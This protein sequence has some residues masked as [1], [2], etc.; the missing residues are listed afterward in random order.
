MVCGLGSVAHDTIPFRMPS[1]TAAS[2]WTMRGAVVCLVMTAVFVACLSGAAEGLHTTD[3]GEVLPLPGCTNDAVSNLM[4]DVGWG[5]RKP[6]GFDAEIVIET[7]GRESNEVVSYVCAYILK[8][9]GFSNVTLVRRLSKSG[10]VSPSPEIVNRLAT[11][12]SHVYLEGHMDSY[13]IDVNH[14]IE[15]FGPIGYIVLPGLYIPEYVDTRNSKT[16]TPNIEW[17]TDASKLKLFI[18]STAYPGG[19]TDSGWYYCGNE[20]N[21]SYTGCVAGKF[22]PPWCRA[23]NATLNPGARYPH[24]LASCIDI[25]AY[26]AKENRSASLEALVTSLGLNA[27]ISYMTTDELRVRTAAAYK[28]GLAFVLFAYFPD[29]FALDYDV[30]RVAF[31]D[32]S[33]QHCQTTYDHSTSVGCDFVPEIYLK[34]G[35]VTLRSFAPDVPK[36]LTS[37]ELKTSEIIE[38]LL[39]YAAGNTTAAA[40]CLWVGRNQNTVRLFIPTGPGNSTDSV[41]YVGSSTISGRIVAVIVGVVVTVVVFAGVVIVLLSRTLLR[42]RMAY[43]KQSQRHRNIIPLEEIVFGEMVGNGSFG[44]VFKGTWRGTQVAI[45]VFKMRG[46]AGIPDHTMSVSA[47]DISSASSRAHRPHLRSVPESAPIARVSVPHEQESTLSH[48][49]SE[50]GEPVDTSTLEGAVDVHGHRDKD[51]EE[52][53][54][55]IL[56]AAEE[57][58]SDRKSSESVVVSVTEVKEGN[59][60]AAAPARRASGSAVAVPVPGPVADRSSVFRASLQLHRRDSHK[61]SSTTMSKQHA[62]PSAPH[63]PTHAHATT[64]GNWMAVEA[65]FDNLRKATAPLARGTLASVTGLW[66]R[67]GRD[68]GSSSSIARSKSSTSVSPTSSSDSARARRVASIAWFKEAARKI[69]EEIDIMCTLRHP[70]VLLF[71]GSCA[72]PN[73]C[74]VTE[75]M[76][77]NLYQL[78][79]DS[80]VELKW[81]RKLAM[82]ADA[83]RGVAYLHASNI[84]HCDLK[85]SNLLVNEQ[86]IV[87]VSDFGLTQLRHPNDA[88]DPHNA[89]RLGTILWQAP[90]VL[91]GSR[92]TQ[93]ADCYSF[94]IILWEILTRSV[95]YASIGLD[96]RGPNAAQS[97]VT[98]V[99]EIVRFNVRPSI[100]DT[101][102]PEYAQLIKRCWTPE[103]LERPPFSEILD[104]LTK[105]EEELADAEAGVGALTGKIMRSGHLAMRDS[106][107]KYRVCWFV[108]DHQYLRCFKSQYHEVAIVAIRAT[109]ICA[110][111]REIKRTHNPPYRITIGSSNRSPLHLG[112]YTATERDSW[113]EALNALL[114]LLERRRSKTTMHSV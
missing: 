108:L 107:D 56:V 34:L 60:V 1:S 18:N 87:K 9:M 19:L 92:Y 63:P 12:M 24:A 17:F 61:R 103:P 73:L 39:W 54:D 84:M 26:P 95:P 105:I 41:G 50:G 29:P 36:L 20:Y 114:T 112:T 96:L 70:N 59:G 94:G 53:V 42:K 88:P 89:N 113:M 40:A 45:K 22:V 44:V 74:M 48:E 32:P 109:D 101:C 51:V 57:E 97:L 80:K 77:S 58:T 2:A 75:Y 13:E 46:A 64:Q 100:P 3:G 16:F 11:G 93:A 86:G 55:E 7:N 99:E 28:S 35:S 4:V 31:P 49:L 81:Q 25:W 98:L 6:K 82:A 102:V 106:N 78:L 76:T 33:N 90:E 52:M 104:A 27:T 85:S 91:L 15:S 43:E 38:P 23:T 47:T 65:L 14:A 110:I 67:A 8:S 69:S 5:Y 10:D 79:H 66:R 68:G 72:W 21:A 30:H 83:T 71:M 37:L 111:G 62:A